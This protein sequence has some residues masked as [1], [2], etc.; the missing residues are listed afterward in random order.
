MWEKNSFSPFYPF[1]IHILKITDNDKLLDLNFQLELTA[2][3][4]K[5]DSFWV[6]SKNTENY[7]EGYII[8]F[9]I[10]L[11]HDDIPK[12]IEKFS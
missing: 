6:I 8:S 12:K 9:I 11:M 4:K 7:V 5:S 10:T 2:R 1:Y 3:K